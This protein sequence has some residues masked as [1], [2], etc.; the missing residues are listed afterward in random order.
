VDLVWGHSPQLHVARGAKASLIPHGGPSR[1]VDGHRLQPALAV[2]LQDPGGPRLADEWAASRTLLGPGAGA[3]G[4]IRV[5]PT[6]PKL[7]AQAVPGVQ[8]APEHP[9]E[10]LAVIVTP[11]VATRATGEVDSVLKALLAVAMYCRL[12]GRLET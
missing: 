2:Q 7:R 10:G 5:G 12:A 9:L 11:E 6:Q 3:A 8:V 4:H 1:S